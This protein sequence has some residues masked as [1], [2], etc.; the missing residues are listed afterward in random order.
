[1][2]A[3]KSAAV[4]KADD[5]PFY[6]DAI[7][8]GMRDMGAW[9]PA[10][11]GALGAIPVGMAAAGPGMFW[12][13]LGG[14]LMGMGRGNT[15]EGLGRGVIRGGMTTG[16]L[17]AGAAL[18]AGLGG[19]I[20]GLPGV[21]LGGLLGGGL[22]GY[23]GWRLAGN[24]MGR[25]SGSAK[26]PLHPLPPQ[27][28]E[29]EKREKKGELD[30]EFYR[31]TFPLYAMHRQS[32]KSIG[33]SW[34]LAHQGA[35]EQ[36]RKQAHANHI[37]DTILGGLTGA[38][39]GM[40][41]GAYLG[42]G[43][44]SAALGGLAGAGLG[45]GAGYLLG[46]PKEAMVK[47][48]LFG[49]G[50]P[51][52]VRHHYVMGRN[53][54]DPTQIYHLRPDPGDA[55]LDMYNAEPTAWN[56]LTEPLYLPHQFRA[57]LQTARGIEPGPG[58]SLLRTS[59][60][61]GPA[62]EWE[63]EHEMPDEA[64]HEGPA[65]HEMAVRHKA[66]PAPTGPDY[67]MA[68]LQAIAGLEPTGLPSKPKKGKTKAAAAASHKYST[69]TTSQPMPHERNHVRDKSEGD[70][71]DPEDAPE[72]QN[73]QPRTT[74]VARPP[75]HG[76]SPDHMAGLVRRLKHLSGGGCSKMGSLMKVDDT[77]QAQMPG[78][79]PANDETSPN[80]APS[81]PQN[82]QSGGKK[83]D[84]G[85]K[86][87]KPPGPDEV[88]L[89]DAIS[90]AQA[91]AGC[92]NFDGQACQMLQ[93]PVQPTQTC[94]AFSPSPQMAGISPQGVMA[95]AM[96]AKPFDKGGSW[97]FPYRGRAYEK[98]GNDPLYA[99]SITGAPTQPPIGGS[100]PA[101]SSSIA[102]SKPGQPALSPQPHIPEPS[103][104]DNRR[105][106]GWKAAAVSDYISPDLL[107][108]MQAFP[109]EAMTHIGAHPY[110]YGG[111]LGA[112]GLGLGAG[113]LYGSGA[114]P[115]PK[116]SPG[117]RKKKLQQM[118]EAE[119]TGKQ[120]SLEKEGITHV[121]GGL[122]GTGIGAAT[123][124]H[125]HRG[126]GAFRGMIH[127]H[128][129][130]LLGGLGAGG[131]ALAGM[132]GGPLG[133]GVG[134]GVGGTLGA[135]AGH[136][137]AKHRLGEPSWKR[138]PDIRHTPPPKEKHEPPK[139]KAKGKHAPPKHKAPHHKKAEL[140]PGIVQAILLDSTLDALGKQ[141][142]YPGCRKSR[143][144]QSRQQ[145][146]ATRRRM[147]KHGEAPVDALLG[148]IKQASAEKCGCGCADCPA[149][150]TKEAQ[151][152]GMPTQKVRVQRPE[153]RTGKGQFAWRGRGAQ[154][155][156]DDPT[157]DH[158]G[159]KLGAAAASLALAQPMQ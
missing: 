152:K 81:P 3:V 114:I 140:D 117:D 45:A 80:G 89:R 52:E 147:R 42:G 132:P 54:D 100:P 98:R 126:E 139:H 94:D 66:A 88:H 36:R 120:A 105:T 64:W 16:G 11:V 65:G 77:D 78:D 127:G 43:P 121:I 72:H 51:D 31:T 60:R 62:A 134:A 34:H 112:L 157:Y 30:E 12:G 104:L 83:D 123:A 143:K 61:E 58:S 153:T 93:M 19:S 87:N 27:E 119:A 107:A 133:M 108:R 150:G 24:L 6:T 13:G 29:E 57:A 7:P 48:G 68:R 71:D 129:I 73:I 151:P 26:P 148:I 25:P 141:G 4:K 5:R 90:P 10:A 20:G 85:D 9:A 74:D 156:R 130:G 14:G 97:P 63:A 92:A 46:R 55:G 79:T 44:G 8:P 135:A 2:A 76:L 116:L 50:D 1:M 56:R 96:A 53:P 37:G 145:A 106:E 59:I 49:W 15:P 47:A 144:T 128:R 136:A 23:G 33:E 84:G 115:L 39:P 118:V 38:L 102:G 159:T 149:C 113:G 86:G 67:A 111:A 154:D 18:G 82:P 35:E 122:L 109:G 131:G 124:P 95:D 91:C 21:A 146:K 28:E 22:G 125:G 40:M 103:W 41:T 70:W 75:Q 99:G 110:A 142:H 155:L 17:G 32:G 101:V 138:G 69:G 137:W 158:F